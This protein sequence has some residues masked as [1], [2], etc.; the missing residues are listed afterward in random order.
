V[1]HFAYSF[2]SNYKPRTYFWPLGLKPH[3]LSSIKGATRRSLIAGV[4]A[5]DLDADIPRVLLQAALPEPLRQFVGRLHPS[6]MGGEYLPDLILNEVEIARITIASTTQDVTCV[7]AR[8]VEDGIF[9]RVVDEYDGGTLSSKRGRKFA[10]P[11]SLGKL[12]KFFLSR[13]SL[14]DVLQMNFEGEG[15]PSE[16]VL[17][18]FR[19]SSDFYPGFDDLL[20]YRVW[21]WLKQQSSPV[22][23]EDEAHL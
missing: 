14:L 16:E 20:R 22:E 23:L 3:P 11:P 12:A 15:Y 2:D 21:N 10:E 7:Y 5:E 1:S 17:R 18:F 8:Q 13:W 6:G 9:L 4:L 19:A